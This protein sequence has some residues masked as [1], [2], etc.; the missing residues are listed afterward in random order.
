[1]KHDNRLLN[2]DVL[3]CLAETQLVPS[4]STEKIEDLPEFSLTYQNVSS[5]V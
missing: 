4:Q 3:L 1:M 5:L 2:T